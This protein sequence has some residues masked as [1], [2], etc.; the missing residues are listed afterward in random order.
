MFQMFGP[1]CLSFALAAPQLHPAKTL[2]A[3]GIQRSAQAVE[4]AFQR[5]TV[6]RVSQNE[7]WQAIFPTPAGRSPEELAEAFTGW[8]AGLADQ[9]QDPSHLRIVPSEGS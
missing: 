3:S 7:L 5:M 8:L 2:G 4:A 6:R 9:T 1:L